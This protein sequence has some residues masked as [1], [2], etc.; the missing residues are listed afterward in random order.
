MERGWDGGG[1]EGGGLNEAA[2]IKRI[3]GCHK[4]C[5]ADSVNLIQGACHYSHD[6]RRCATAFENEKRACQALETSHL[7]WDAVKSGR[8][9]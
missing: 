3:V 9:E 4:R 6:F 5:A 8:Y 7:R 2:S 1:N